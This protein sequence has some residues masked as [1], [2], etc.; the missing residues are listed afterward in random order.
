MRE[1]TVAADVEVPLEG[2]PGKIVRGDL[3]LEVFERVR[4]LGAADDLAVAFRGEDVD[5]EKLLQSLL[6]ETRRDLAERYFADPRKSIS[7]VAFLLGFSQQSSLA[8]ASKRWFGMS[9]KAY[10]A[11]HPKRR[12]GSAQRPST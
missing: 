9:P 8:R 10:R 7:D 12:G 2:L 11:S 5:R 3:A 6:D 4:P 1:R